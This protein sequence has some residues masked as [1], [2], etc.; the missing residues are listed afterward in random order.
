MLI[1]IIGES[2][3]G[4]SSLAN[5]LKEKIKATVYTGKDFLRL[6]KNESM[7]RKRFCEI[8]QSAVCGENVIYVISEKEHLNLLPEKAKRIVVTASID[9][10]KSRFAKRMGG[11]L[12]SA[13]EKMLE[14]RHG[15][16]DNLPCDL[17]VNGE[18]FDISAIEIALG[19]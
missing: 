5:L 18:S 4:K 17:R 3:V 1:A 11:V 2:C 7:A 10:I 13:V 15:V 6:E 14:N 8:L 16:F 19:V 12:P 9:V